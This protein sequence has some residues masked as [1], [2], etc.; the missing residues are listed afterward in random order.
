MPA[1]VRKAIESRHV[2]PPTQGHII[3]LAWHD[4]V[5]ARTCIARQRLWQA[6][7]MISGVRDDALALAGLRHGLPTSHGRG[8]D[9]LPSGV[10]AQFEGSLVRKL[11]TEELLRGFRIVIHGLLNETRIADSELGRRLEVALTSLI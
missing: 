5:H 3:G 2:P 6:E 9:L 10:A 8:M 4:A 7:Y 1:D 11:E